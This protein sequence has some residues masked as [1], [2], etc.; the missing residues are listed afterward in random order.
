MTYDFPPRPVLYPGTDSWKILTAVY[1]VL[2]VG[3]VLAGIWYYVRCLRGRLCHRLTPWLWG[4]FGV[5]HL[6]LALIVFDEPWTNRLRLLPPQLVE[7]RTPLIWILAISVTLHSAI[8]LFSPN[9]KAATR[10]GCIAGCIFF[11]AVTLVLAP[12]SLRG[13]LTK[14]D[15]CEFGL[16]RLSQ[17]LSDWKVAHSRF[18]DCQLENDSKPPRSWRIEAFI[19]EWTNRDEFYD[20]A[21]PW[22]SERNRRLSLELASQYTCP[23]T[24]E[25]Q[26]QDELGTPF[27]AWAAPTGNDTAFPGGKGLPPEKFTDGLSNTVLLTEAVGQQIPW[28]EPRDIEVTTDNVGINQ[29]GSRMYHSPSILS[30][31]HDP[32][33]AHVLRADGSVRF[34]GKQTDRRILKAMI[35]PAGGESLMKW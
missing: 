19:E 1:I 4:G 14:S 22:N 21:L 6:V 15:R 27:T 8:A 30:S 5:L 26:R 7:S 10:D 34:L 9:P 2:S 17:V 35:T 24:P 28:I 33:G 3:I 23:A 31:Y 25:S 12:V 20:V 16:R 18:F 11:I 13:T 29:P 32:E